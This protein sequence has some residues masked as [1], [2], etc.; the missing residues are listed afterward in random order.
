MKKAV[1]GIALL[2]AGT[3]AGAGGGWAL[4]TFMPGAIPPAEGA[5][6]APDAGKADD[7]APTSIISA[8]RVLAPLV[9]KDGT[10]AGYSGFQVQVEVPEAEA[11]DITAR[12]PILLH[13]INMRT[14]KTPLAAGPDGMIPDLELFRATVQQ[15]ADE[16]FG[17]GTVKRVLVT[18]ASPA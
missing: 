13:A 14:F 5:N 10:L 2:L 4:L 18:E 6:G 16:T 7:G 3:A 12:L 17:K 11:A 9:Y 15:A 1:L 8:G